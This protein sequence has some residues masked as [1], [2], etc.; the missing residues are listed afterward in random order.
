M[1]TV[2][3]EYKLDEQKRADFGELMNS[4]ADELKMRGAKNYRLLEGMDQP[5]LIVETFDVES[6]EAYQVI[7]A[8]RLADE[9]LCACI[10]GGAAK[11]H[12]WAFIPLQNR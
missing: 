1:V 10:P 12:I 8:W 5:G 2:F 3:M 7:K 6:A 11:L 9:D 4:M